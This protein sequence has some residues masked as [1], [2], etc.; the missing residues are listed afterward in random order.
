MEHLQKFLFYSC[1]NYSR[2]RSQSDI[3]TCVRYGD[4]C[5]GRA[6]IHAQFRMDEMKR[7]DADELKGTEVKII[8]VLNRQI[9]IDR[10]MK[11]NP[12]FC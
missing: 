2:S 6:K 5:F 8:R 11:N 10:D 7:K 1:Q 4:L 9:Q 12:Y 3:P